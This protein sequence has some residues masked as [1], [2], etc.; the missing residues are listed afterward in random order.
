MYSILKIIT[1]I[2]ALPFMAIGF[3]VGFALIG[4][5]AGA[6]LVKEVFQ[7]IDLGDK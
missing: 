5:F 2:I 3:C 1:I 6:A 7:L 4:I